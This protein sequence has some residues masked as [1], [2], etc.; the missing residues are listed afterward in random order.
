MIPSWSRQS[1]SSC[2]RRIVSSLA[3]PMFPEISWECAMEYDNYPEDRDNRRRSR[4]CRSLGGRDAS[5]RIWILVPA[6]PMC[7]ARWGFSTRWVQDLCE[8]VADTPE[9]TKKHGPR[10]KIP[11]HV[12]GGVPHAIPVVAGRLLQYLI[13]RRFLSEIPNLLI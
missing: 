11:D 9:C 4:V 12:Y 8:R 1:C 7:K 13:S 6:A 2:R 5:Q 3:V 10:R